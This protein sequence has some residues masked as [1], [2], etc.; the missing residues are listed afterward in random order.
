[1]GSP[2]HALTAANVKKDAPRFSCVAACVRVFLC[3]CMRVCVSAD[4]HA[5]VPAS[6]GSCPSALEPHLLLLL[7][8]CSLLPLPPALSRP[9]LSKTNGSTLGL[10]IFDGFILF[11]SSHIESQGHP[12]SRP[13]FLSL[14]G[15]PSTIETLRRKSNRLEKKHTH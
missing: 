2:S 14:A 10:V 3:A 8:S 5:C 9:F 4:L 1:M 7:L 12:R 13:L 15:S 11:I 6:Q